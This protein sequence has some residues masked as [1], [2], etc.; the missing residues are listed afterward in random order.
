MSRKKKTYLRQ[1]GQTSDGKKVFTGVYKFYETMGLPLDVMLG[2]FQTKGWMPD[3]IDFYKSARKAGMEH[4]RILSK[5]E[6]AISDSFGKE[7]SD[8]V[9]FTLGDIFN[10]KE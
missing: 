6:E 8:H 1:V 4:D 9:I 3:W 10:P 5:L 2:C 7:F